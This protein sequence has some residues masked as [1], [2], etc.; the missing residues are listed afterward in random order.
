MKTIKITAKEERLLEELLWCNP[1]NS[2]CAYRE[3]N[4]SRKS[5]DECE[6]TKSK[7][8]LMKKLGLNG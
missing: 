7:N 8:S 6:L 5:C 2:G 3:M 4:S 1:C